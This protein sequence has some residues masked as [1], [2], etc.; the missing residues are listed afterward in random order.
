MNIKSILGL[1]KTIYFNFYY[2]PFKVAIKLP[3]MI[4]S[5]VKLAS[6]GTRKSVVLNIPNERV[7][8]GYGESFA[9]GGRTYWNV[10]SEGKVIFDGK[11]SFGKGTQIIS[12]G[13]LR[14]G[15]DFYCNANG[16]INAGK[17]IT[18]GDH[19]LL[20][21]NVTIID[22]DGHKIFHN[23]IVQETYKPIRIGDNVWLGADS[24]VLKGGEIKSGCIVAS[25]GCVTK[26]INE[27][28]IVIGGINKVLNRGITWK[29]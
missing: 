28:G 2:F 5:D 24:T 1:P 23:G 21:W 18:F 17:R 16:I 8:I 25:K 29:K 22:G 20:G 9:L 26:R 19:C 27:E 14:F 13:V 15:K 7:Y 12:A 10:G 3:I 6:M 11:A 4:A